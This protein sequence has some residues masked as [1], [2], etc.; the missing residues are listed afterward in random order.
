MVFDWDEYK[1]GINIAKHG[2]DFWEASSA[3]YDDKAIIFDDPDHSMDE[4]RFLLIGMSKISRVLIVCHCYRGKDEDIRI[5]SARKATKS[6]IDY[7][8]QGGDEL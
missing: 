1:N 5:I 2:V 3:F 4:D 7:Y 8:L 6:E